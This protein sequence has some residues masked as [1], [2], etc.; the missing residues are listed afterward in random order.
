MDAARQWETQ[1]AVRPRC[2]ACGGAGRDLFVKRGYSFAEC[3]SCGCRFVSD[4]LDPLVYDEGYFRGDSFGG[5][6]AYREDRELLVRNF[7][8]RIEWL[9][10]LAPGSRLLDVGAA[11]GFLVH[12]AAQAGF[13]ATGM[14][15][16]AGCVEWARRELGVPMIEARAEDATIA[17]QS[18]DVVTLLDVIEHVVDPAV[19][20]RRVRRWL[21]PGGLLVIETGD[22]ESL[23]AR[24]CGRRW[25]YYDPPQHLT[26][27]S[28]ASLR[29]VLDAAGFDPLL[30]TGHL[31]RAVSMRNFSH[32]LGRS[33]GDGVAG[34]VCRRF[35]QSRLGSLTFEVP[36]RGNVMLT[37]SR[38]RSG[39]WTPRASSS[40]GVGSRARAPL[41][42][43]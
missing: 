21:R 1:E 6:P 29:H 5:Y 25:Y 31:S 26:Y 9:A 32:Q 27:F 2:R 12:A 38:S 28:E 7:R 19:V 18:F 23:L 40:A 13:E 36:D 15:P 14:E 4:A 16:A 17:P 30:A 35:A 8:R 3:E 41:A 22:F 42:V 37:A 20:L 43:P 34:D 39:G 24:T 10:P 11:Y 33:L